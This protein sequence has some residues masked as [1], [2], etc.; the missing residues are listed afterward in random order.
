MG[1]MTE[2]K[3]FGAFAIKY[4]GMPTEAMPLYSATSGYKRKA[5]RI[6]ARILKSGNMGQ[7]CD[8]SYR[9]KEPQWKADIITM[10]HRVGEYFGLMRIFP[11]DATVF[12]KNYLKQKLPW[13]K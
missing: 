1:L 5:N 11:W 4:L 6:C 12:M 13:N 2:W 7:N 10:G 3:A 8:G 9:L